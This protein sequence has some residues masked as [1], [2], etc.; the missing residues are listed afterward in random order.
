MVQTA[1]AN[2]ASGRFLRSTGAQVSSPGL[3]HGLRALAVGTLSLCGAQVVLAKTGVKHLHAAA[4]SF[5]VGIY[6]EANGHGTAL[7]SP[8]AV[9]ALQK[10]APKAQSE[11]GTALRRLRALAAVTNPAVGDAASGILAVEALLRLQTMSLADWD[12]LYRDLP[13]CQVKVKVPDRSA[14][15]TVDAE[16]RCVAPD[17]LQAAVDVA[18]AAAPQ[19]RRAG[20]TAFLRKCTR[21]TFIWPASAGRSCARRGRRTVSESTQKQPTQSPQLRWPRLSATP[22][23]PSAAKNSMTPNEECLVFGCF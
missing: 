6:F 14:I 2:G 3:R 18:V 20:G 4:E 12:A 11:T 8:A 10:D 22:W 21:W 5:D 19:G 1:Y 7:F 17:G 16:T 9:L 15:V 13:S 23:L